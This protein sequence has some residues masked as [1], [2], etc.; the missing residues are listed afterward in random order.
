MTNLQYAE[1]LSDE[2]LQK[3][4]YRRFKPESKVCAECEMKLATQECRQC[5][6]V[7]CDECNERLHK[8]ALDELNS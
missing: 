3:V 1:F 5:D 4:G 2:E 8:S 6:D 7:F